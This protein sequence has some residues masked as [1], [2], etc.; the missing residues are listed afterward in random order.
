[1]RCPGA[2]AEM[3]GEPT[4]ARI[5]RGAAG[6]KTASTFPHS[7]T[8]ATEL[9]NDI[10]VLAD[11]FAAAPPFPGLPKTWLPPGL[12]SGRAFTRY[13]VCGGAVVHVALKVEGLCRRSGACASL[14]PLRPAQGY[15]RSL[16]HQFAPGGNEPPLAIHEQLE[17]SPG[18]RLDHD[19]S[20]RRPSPL[21]VRE[22]GLHPIRRA[23]QVGAP[24]FSIS[25]AV[26]EAGIG[27]S[28]VLCEARPHSS[29]RIYTGT[30]VDGHDRSYRLRAG[31]GSKLLLAS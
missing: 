7:P 14:A 31:A 19:C 30:V 22:P 9:R 4:L 25:R 26:G 11:A 17:V 21:V 6:A 13:K 18:Y 8:A 16:A 28:R 27:N 3:S 10:V 20:R 23:R 29:L 24:K 5:P 1:M 15:V 2:G 12:H